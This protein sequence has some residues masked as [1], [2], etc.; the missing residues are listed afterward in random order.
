[1][2]IAA[3]TPTGH[4]SIVRAF[5]QKEKQTLLMTSG[6]RA[7]QRGKIHEIEQALDSLNAISAALRGKGE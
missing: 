3:V 2:N 6:G 4:V 1:M 5:L 7:H